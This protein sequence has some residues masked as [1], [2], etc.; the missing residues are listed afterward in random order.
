MNRLR[1]ES[2][3]YL[4]QHADNPVDWFPWHPEAFEKA[5]REDKPILV[6]IGYATCHW[7][8]VMEH[9]SFEDEETAGFMND[10]FVCIKVDREERPDVDQIYMDACQ[11]L[12]GSGG[13][14]LNCFLTPDG[15]PFHAGTYYPPTP[16]HNRPSW[17]QVLLH[18][19]KA[20]RDQRRTVEEQA[21]RLTNILRKGSGPAPA[22]ILPSD[23]SLAFRQ[24]MLH[25]AYTKMA[26]N[27]DRNFGGFGHAPKF[28]GTMSLQ[29]LLHYQYAFQHPEALDHA[30]LSLGKM[31]MGG[32]FD[33]LG[34]G[35]A[36]YA[37]DAAWQIPHFEK[38]LYDNA[39]LVSLLSNV[40]RLTHDS[41]WLDVIRLTLDWVGREMTDPQ[42]GFYSAIDADS[43]GVEGKFYTWTDDEIQNALG[44]EADLFRHC[45]HIRPTGNWEGTNILYRTS[46]WSELAGE[47][48]IPVR[49]LKERI[50]NCRQ[51]LFLHRA[52]RTRPIL[53]DKVLLDWNSLMCTA[54][55]DAYT[56]TLDPCYRT[57]AENNLD[58]LLRAFRIAGSN[59][60]L[61]TW[62]NGQARIHAFLDDYAFLVQ[63][64]LA[65]AEIS[66]RHELLLEAGRLID[67]VLDQFL[68][69]AE[70]AFFFT[71]RDHHDLL[72]RKKDRFDGATPSGNAVMVS[73][74]QRA[75]ILLDRPDWRTLAE[76]CLRANLDPLLKF[77][78]SHGQWAC[79]LFD[80]VFPIPEIA[81]L[82]PDAVQLSE[83]LLLDYIP[84]RVLMAAPE[85]IQT[86]PLL[87]GKSDVP[88]NN[89]FFVCSNYA[90]AYPTDDP[91]TC[92]TI[93]RQRI[94]E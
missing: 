13:W 17:L 21:D 10:H 30:L 31:S 47:L 27:F 23:D 9:E 85:P 93:L 67:H 72:L 55:A 90:C 87:A 84:Y 94:S 37:T 3:P 4:L 28:P 59:D 43:E 40:L 74:L 66:R 82:G 2:S 41:E 64:M 50:E 65:V 44:K 29:F 62:K 36:R 32:I 39:L 38:M 81:V 51:S 91:D 35:F 16:A 34:G 24:D 70:P 14:P 52:Q 8:H 56:A 54:F 63:A 19:A 77:P 58:F 20:F 53:D 33:H 18:M 88:G 11:I 45:F 25:E 73:N 61:H 46:Q 49:E 60:F 89:R 76:K 57:T 22:P 69:P 12:T 48:N 7:C 71:S 1:S 86:F 6:S 92:K 80:A 78:T 15:R 75:G 79:A 68:D 5:R 83:Q 42:G 26:A